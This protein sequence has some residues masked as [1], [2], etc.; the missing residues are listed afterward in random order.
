M[1]KMPPE[2]NKTILDNKIGYLSN[3]KT[4]LNFDIF[5]VSG[6]NECVQSQLN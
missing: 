1:N 3:K 4:W 6:G 5:N 2:L